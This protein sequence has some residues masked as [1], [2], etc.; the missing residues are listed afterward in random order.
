[1]VDIAETVE[2]I[3]IKAYNTSE[4]LIDEISTFANKSIPVIGEALEDAG[5]FVVHQAKVIS[6]STIY[7]KAEEYVDE[8]GDYIK[9]IFSTNKNETYRTTEIIDD[10]RMI[11]NANKNIRNMNN[12]GTKKA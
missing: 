12:I 6:N 10:D 8:A 2:N 9:G 5:E 11:N 1:L 3:A 7:K 4:I